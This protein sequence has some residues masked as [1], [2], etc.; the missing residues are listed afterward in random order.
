M[1]SQPTSQISLLWKHVPLVTIVPLCYRSPQSVDS[2]MQESEYF[3]INDITDNGEDDN[4]EPLVPRACAAP[5]QNTVDTVNS[6]L[7]DP[8]ATGTQPKPRSALDIC[9]FFKKHKGEHTVCMPC[10]NMKA[11]NPGQFPPDHMYTYSAATSNTSLHFHI[12]KYHLEEFL[13]E[14]ECQGWVVQIDSV[15]AAFSI[16]Y[17]YAMLW[18]VLSHPNIS[19]HLLPPAP[20]PRPNDEPPAFISPCPPPLGAGLPPFSISALH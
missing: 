8:L 7:T 6:T 16:H 14:A 4:E 5:S 20:P 12:E 3:N 19:I 9:H 2:N 1:Y 15:R 18:E 11:Q 10:K 17:N 13:A